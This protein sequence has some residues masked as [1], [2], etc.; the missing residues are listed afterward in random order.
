MPIKQ[1][2]PKNDSA[3]VFPENARVEKRDS[4]YSGK[5]NQSDV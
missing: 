3:L 2:L 4:Q 5:K 1:T